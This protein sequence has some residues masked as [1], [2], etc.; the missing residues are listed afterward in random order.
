MLTL[1]SDRMIRMQ[2]AVWRRR[3]DRV[4]GAREGIVPDPGAVHRGVELP[5]EYPGRR[6]AVGVVRQEQVVLALGV[7]VAPADAL[8]D[9]HGAGH[10]VRRPEPSLALADRDEEPLR[11]VRDLDVVVA[12]RVEL[13]DRRANERVSDEQ[14]QVV[15]LVRHGHAADGH[16]LGSHLPGGV[17]QLPVG[18]AFLRHERGKAKERPR[19]VLLAGSRRGG[20]PVDHALVARDLEHVAER[21]RERVAGRRRQVRA[22]PRERVLH[23]LE[24]VAGPQ[25]PDI[26]LRK[27]PHETPRVVVEG[28][29][30][31]P[32]VVGV[33]LAALCQ[34]LSLQHKALGIGLEAVLALCRRIRGADLGG[35]FFCGP[36][37][38]NPVRLFGGAHLVAM[39]SWIQNAREVEGTG[40]G[41][42]RAPGRV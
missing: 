35:Q 24:V 32:N 19:V 26:P 1:P 8:V 4:I 23:E 22:L 33:P 17:Q 41:L 2:I 15:E 9:R 10:R 27:V 39:R 5:L 25:L 42:D 11:L 12:D 28:Q 21:R 34:L 37:R 31:G 40:M 18:V 38:V 29:P 14:D 16:A 13:G 36:S 7:G 3:V 6:G 20:D 30:G